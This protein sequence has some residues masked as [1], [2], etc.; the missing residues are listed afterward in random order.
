MRASLTFGATVAVRF[1]NGN[2]YD[3]TTDT[4]YGAD[5]PRAPYVE[6]DKPSKKK[7]K[8]SEKRNR[9]MTFSNGAEYDFHT[10]EAKPPPPK[11]PYTYNVSNYYLNTYSNATT[12][13]NNYFKQRIL[14][15][16]ALPEADR[17]DGVF[18]LRKGV[19]EITLRRLYGALAA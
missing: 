7:I 4:F 11:N 6:P 8:K 18:V 16:D 13:K 14:K 19:P 5:D 12:I 2:I 9:K 1:S 17:P 3:G 15:Q 10:G